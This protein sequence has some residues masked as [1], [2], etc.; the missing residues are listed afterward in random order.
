MAAVKKTKRI[1]RTKAEIED[2]KDKAYAQFGDIL[3]DVFQKFTA[4]DRAA[5]EAKQK[6]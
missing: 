4:K 3:N 5:L 2:A 1:R 6:Q